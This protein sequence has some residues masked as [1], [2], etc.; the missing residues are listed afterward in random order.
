[1][2]SSG[3]ANGAI[4]SYPIRGLVSAHGNVDAQ[5]GSVSMR[6]NNAILWFKACIG[7]G[8]AG[9]MVMSCGGAD[10]ARKPVAMGDSGS[11]GSTSGNGGSSGEGGSGATS[12]SPGEGG[13]SGT[14]SEAGHGGSGTGTGGPAGEGVRGAG[15]AGAEW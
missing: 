12:G 6:R 2:S 7:C 5:G 9:A 3:S 10:D 4:A 11:A 1:M 14:R 8:V 15:S 13:V